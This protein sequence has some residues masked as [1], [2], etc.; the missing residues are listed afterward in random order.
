[1]AICFREWR[2]RRR[3]KDLS[4]RLAARRMRTRVL[5]RLKR[6][7][8]SY[9]TPSLRRRR[10]RK[11]YM[12]PS[13]KRG[14]RKKTRF[15]IPS[16]IQKRRKRQKAWWIRSL[17]QRRSCTTPSLNQKRRKNFPTPSL[18]Q[19]RK[20]RRTLSSTHSHR[21]TSQHTPFPRRNQ[22]SNTASISSSP[23]PTSLSS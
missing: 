21:R 15:P 11:S 19:R 1:M 22:P 14:K 10:R 23:R 2:R 17:E 8:K 13:Q 6:R 7:K 18:N 3:V 16:L 20:R 9:M 12:T 4:I 5:F